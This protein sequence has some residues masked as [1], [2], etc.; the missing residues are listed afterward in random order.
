VDLPAYEEDITV[1]N[2][3]NSLYA[4]SKKISIQVVLELHQNNFRMCEK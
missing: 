2:T 4:N 1:E 3:Y